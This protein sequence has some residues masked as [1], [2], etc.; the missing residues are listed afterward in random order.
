MKLNNLVMALPVASVPK[1]FWNRIG[2]VKG[3]SLTGAY[4]YVKIRPDG[5]MKCFRPDEVKKVLK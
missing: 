5:I 1:I 2:E 3:E 4:L